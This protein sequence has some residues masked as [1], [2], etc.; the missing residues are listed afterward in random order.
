MVKWWKERSDW[1]NTV[2]ER[3][4]SDIFETKSPPNPKCCIY[5]SVSVLV[6]SFSEMHDMNCQ[7]RHDQIQCSFLEKLSESSDKGQTKKASRPDIWGFMGP[8]GPAACPVL[9]I[10]GCISPLQLNFLSW[11][12]SIEFVPKDS[13]TRLGFF[14]FHVWLC[15]FQGLCCEDD[16]AEVSGRNTRREIE[17]RNSAAIQCRL[18]CGQVVSNWMFLFV[19]LR[20]LSKR[21]SWMLTSKMTR[22]ALSARRPRLENWVAS[23]CWTTK[24]IASIVTMTEPTLG[25]TLPS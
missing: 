9:K 11:R 13:F 20:E 21:E 7:P 17:S 15:R 10:C 3:L 5:G 12:R 16:D 8:F 4:P 25:G 18:S 1:K 24:E 14:A 6:C 23:K 2:C 19:V 22:R